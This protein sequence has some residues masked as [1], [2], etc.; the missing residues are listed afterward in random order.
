VTS[1]L[2]KNNAR[3][4]IKKRGLQEQQPELKRVLMTR[5]ENP[6]KV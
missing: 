6:I 3:E 2:K 4:Q 5:I 1:P